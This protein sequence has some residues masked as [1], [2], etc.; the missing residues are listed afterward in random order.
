MAWPTRASAW[1]GKYHPFDHDGKVG[2]RI[3][4]YTGDSVYSSRL[5]AEGS[6]IHCIRQ[7]DPLGATR[8]WQA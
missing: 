6:R 5:V 3:A 4:E 7:Q 1:G 2:A 8:A